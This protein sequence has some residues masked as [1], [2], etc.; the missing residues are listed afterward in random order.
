MLVWLDLV[1]EG[2]VSVKVSKAWLRTAH[3]AE[4]FGFYA[5]GGMIEKVGSNLHRLAHF[6]F[7]THSPETSET[8]VL[9]GTKMA[10]SGLWRE[11]WGWASWERVGPAPKARRQR[12]F[13][14]ADTYLE[15]ELV[16]SKEGGASSTVIGGKAGNCDIPSRSPWLRCEG[17]NKQKGAFLW[18][19]HQRNESQWRVSW[20]YVGQGGRGSSLHAGKWGPLAAAAEGYSQPTAIEIHLKDTR[21]FQNSAVCLLRWLKCTQNLFWSSSYRLLL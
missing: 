10:A 3:H 9:R 19:G 5:I 17:E 8:Q 16:S 11:L 15:D 6:H 1:H 13:K 20:G 7:R 14:K 21:N 12:K 18:N 2:E 4:D